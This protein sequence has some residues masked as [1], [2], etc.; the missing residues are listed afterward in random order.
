LAEGAASSILLRILD[1]TITTALLKHVI[2]T[3]TVDFKLFLQKRLAVQDAIQK[4]DRGAKCAAVR[5][6]MELTDRT[7]VTEAQV[8][9]IGMIAIPA[10]TGANAGKPFTVCFLEIAAK[11]AR[12]KLDSGQAHRGGSMMEELQYIYSILLKSPALVPLL[13]VFDYE[14]ANLTGSTAA[15]RQ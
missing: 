7:S 12:E 14:F 6:L 11:V 4:L 8:H 9:K 1:V 10:G 3:L 5:V 15:V 2:F 13:G